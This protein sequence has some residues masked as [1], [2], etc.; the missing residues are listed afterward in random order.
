MTVPTEPGYRAGLLVVHPQRPEWG[1]GRV[2]SVDGT[3]I[4]VYFRDLPGEHPEAAVRTIETRYVSLDA[5]TDQSDPFLK[6]LPPYANGRFE[7]PLKRRVTLREGIDLFGSLYPLFFEDPGYLKHAEGGEREYKWRAHEKFVSTLG[8]GRLAALLADGEVA[9]IRR[10]V[11]A[12][13]GLLNLVSIYEKPAL[14]DGLAD[15]S[16]AL[17]LFSALRRVLEAPGVDPALFEEYL[18][19]VES[20]PSEAGKTSPAKWTIATILPFVADPVRF[21]FLKPAVTQQCAERL[22]FDLAYRPQLNWVTYS[23]L[24]AMAGI[25]LAALRPYG[26]R[27]FIDVQSFIWRIGDGGD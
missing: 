26:A 2:L 1:P 23:R 8:G 14:R 25:L 17:R 5:A 16:G 13:E 24:L 15:D 27:D 6:N 3:K 4:T 9:E 19:A 10:R 22:T 20:L 12:V 18:A 11:L 7:R 21:M